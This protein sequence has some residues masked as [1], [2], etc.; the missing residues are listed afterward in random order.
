MPNAVLAVDEEGGD[1]TR[2]HATTGSPFLG[3]GALGAADD[4]H[5]TRAT[6]AAI[7]AELADLGL[8]LT[9]G[10]VADVNSNPDNPVIGVRSFGSTASSRPGPRRVRSISRAT[11]T[12]ARTA[13]SSCPRSR[14]RS[15]C[16]NGAS[17]CRSG[18]LSTPASRR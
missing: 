9:L 2:L 18:R 6:A 14:C 10:P 5:L 3:A 12:P 17:W 4:L 13:T 16:S 8:D 1:V 7:G 15:T 11:A